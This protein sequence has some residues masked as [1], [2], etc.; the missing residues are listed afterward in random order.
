MIFLK[1]QSLEL[2]VLQKNAFFLI[3]CEDISDGVFDWDNF[4]CVFVFVVGCI[5]LGLFSFLVDF[6]GPAMQ[7]QVIWTCAMIFHNTNKKHKL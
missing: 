5:L 7:F 6:A 2:E 3:L 1:T 4:K